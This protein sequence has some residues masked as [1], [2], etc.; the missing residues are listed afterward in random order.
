MSTK[1]KKSD[2]FIFG[3]TAGTSLVFILQLLSYDELTI[4]LQVALYTFCIVLP[5]SATMYMVID[6]YESKIIPDAWY[7]DWLM[8]IAMFGCAAGICLTIVYHSIISAVIFFIFS[9]C[10]VLILN[11]L[12]KLNTD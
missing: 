12:Y 9:L 3:V 4:S 2:K 11:T 7:I 8:N 1:Y 5:C 10:G 6:S